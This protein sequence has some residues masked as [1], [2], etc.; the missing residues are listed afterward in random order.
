MNQWEAYTRG[1]DSYQLAVRFLCT[2]WK[3][4]HPLQKSDEAD[5]VADDQDTYQ[6]PTNDGRCIKAEGQAAIRQINARITV[7]LTVLSN[8]DEIQR[9]KEEIYFAALDL[10]KKPS[11]REIFLSLK[12]EKRLIWFFFLCSKV[13][14][15]SSIVA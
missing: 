6:P 5:D 11:A 1:R 7:Y 13:N 8:L 12:V 4:N 15:E 9:V 3:R 2:L 10:F 14:W